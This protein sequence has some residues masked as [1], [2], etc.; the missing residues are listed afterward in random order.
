MRL[1]ALPHP[2][3]DARRGG[4]VVTEAGEGRGGA[5]PRAALFRVVLDLDQPP[6]VQR[7]HRVRAA[8]DAAPQSL[9][10]RWSSALI[11]TLVR[12]SGL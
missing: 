7:M 5:K 9:W 10:E 6:P 1:Q 3:L 12:E 11:A 4:P 8:V 2:L